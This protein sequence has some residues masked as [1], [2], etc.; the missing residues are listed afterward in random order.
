MVIRKSSGQRRRGGDVRLGLIGATMHWQ[1]YAPGL[2]NFKDLHLAAVAPS[3]PEETLGAFDHAP[4]LTVETRRYEDARKMLDA[5]KLDIVQVCPRPDR[6][7]HWAQVCLERGIPALVEKP[8]AMD[9]PTLERLYTLVVK[10]GTPLLPMH[11]M[12]GEPPLAAMALSISRGEIGAPMVGFSQKS[13]KWGKSREDWFKSR[14]TFPGIMP[15]IG[16]HAL[17]WLYWMLGDVFTE[18]HG[19][20]SSAAHP[21]YPACAGHAAYTFKMKNGG[22][23]AVTLDYLRPDKAPTHG[24]ERVRIAGTKGVVE[25]ILNDRRVTLLTHD[26]PPATLPLEPQPD[27]FTAFVRSIRKEG[28]PVMSHYDAFRITEIALKAQQA[29]DTGRAISL[30]TGLRVRRSG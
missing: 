24:D 12:R 26:T 20:E 2:S 15:F 25:T 3:G 14:R 7:A 11:T 19:S 17:D 4:G 22:A 8:L 13:Y 29:A 6:I 23:V 1:T 28:R 9:I 18:V 21:D 30:E 16:I 5:E 10:T 27:I